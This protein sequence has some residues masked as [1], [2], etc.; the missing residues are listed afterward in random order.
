[1][2]GGGS[3]N[4]DSVNE[5][6]CFYR[7]LY[8]QIA[9]QLDA[10]DRATLADMLDAGSRA[11]VQAIADRLRRGLFPFLRTVSWRVYDRYLKANRVDQGVRSYDEVLTLI[12]RARF[13][14]GR[15]PRTRG[16]D[17]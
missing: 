9:G 7:L 1:M 15:T 16:R 4:G 2:Q 6:G 5:D 11:D 12:L 14:D 10:S 13:D 3:H 17:Q 8:G